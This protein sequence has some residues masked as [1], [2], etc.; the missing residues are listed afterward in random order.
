MMLIHVLLIMH[1]SFNCLSRLHIAALLRYH[2]LRLLVE[3][4]LEAL[5]VHRGSLRLVGQGLLSF[6]L[7]ASLRHELQSAHFQLLNSG[8]I[9][10]RH[11]VLLIARVD[12][13][14]DSLGLSHDEFGSI[15]SLVSQSARLLL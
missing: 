3:N 8:H 2:R 6:D 4:W 15:F 10:L 13:L 14:C 12:V 5:I 9:Y 7:S 11:V 1:S